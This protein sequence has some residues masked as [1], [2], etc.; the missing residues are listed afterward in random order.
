M[1]KRQTMRC[2]LEDGGETYGVEVKVTEVDG[3]NVKFDIQVDDE[4]E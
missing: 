2:K 4:P 1:Y 3:N